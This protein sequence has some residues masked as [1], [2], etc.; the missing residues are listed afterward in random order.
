LKSNKRFKTTSGKRRKQLDE[1][2]I[3]FLDRT[4]GKTKLAEKLRDGGFCIVTHYEEY[5]DH[6]HNLPDPAI[7]SDCGLKQRVLLTGDQDLVHTYA[8][9]IRKARI[10]VFVTT[11]NNEGPEYWAKRIIDARRDIW[12]ELFRRKK[13]FTARIS[14]LGKITQVRVYERRHWKTITIGKRNPPHENRQKQRERD[15]AREQASQQA[16]EPLSSEIR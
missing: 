11:D 15:E 9:E 14:A 8:L 1:P 4:F 3:F 6:G 5:G 12:R 7:V 13:P 16:I 10:A 2:P